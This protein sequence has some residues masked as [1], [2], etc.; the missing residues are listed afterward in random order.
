MVKNLPANVGD[1]DS[2]PG[3]GRLYRHN[4]NYVLGLNIK[5]L[6]ELIYLVL[7]LSHTFYKIPFTNYFP[8]FVFVPKRASARLPDRVL[9]R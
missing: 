7:N 4:I 3:L 1:I 8:V 5:I 9:R 2:T 6:C